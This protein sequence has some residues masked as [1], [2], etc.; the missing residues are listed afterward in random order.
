MRKVIDFNTWTCPVSLI[1][2]LSQKNIAF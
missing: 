2:K 1:Y